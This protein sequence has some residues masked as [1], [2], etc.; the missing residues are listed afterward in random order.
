MNEPWSTGCF[1][2]GLTFFLDLL[3]LSFGRILW[4]IRT[5]RFWLYF[6]LHF[7]LAC[8]GAYLI[9]EEIV[10]WYLRALV[11]TFLG[12]AILSNADVKLAGYSLLPISQLFTGIKARMTEQAGEDKARALL[13]AKLVERIQKLSAAKI[14]AAYRAALVAAG[15]GAEKIQAK[16][17]RARAR[18]AGNE[19]YLKTELLGGLV[20]VNLD[21]VEQ[22]LPSWEKEQ[23]RLP[24]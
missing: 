24:G 2:L 16:I 15:L 13:K 1:I 14:E 10:E 18:A 6:V 21:Y 5:L 7:G 3:E 23:D 22:N 20:S 12:V 8:L 11:G 17:D 4:F 9:R 19:E